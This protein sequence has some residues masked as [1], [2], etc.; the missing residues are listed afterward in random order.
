MSIL[1][2]ALKRAGLK[3]QADA[4]VKEQRTVRC[5]QKFIREIRAGE[6]EILDIFSETQRDLTDALTKNL[7]LHERVRFLEAELIQSRLKNG[8]EQVAS[9]TQIDRANLLEL[10]TISNGHD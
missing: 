1:E 6:S 10:S 4:L 8:L 7:E 9:L 3:I 5:F 2:K